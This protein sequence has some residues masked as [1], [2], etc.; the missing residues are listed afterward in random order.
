MNAGAKS[1]RDL[2]GVDTLLHSSEIKPLLERHSH[3]LV[4]YAIHQVLNKC[5]EQ[6]EA[7]L[8][9]PVMNHIACLVKKE[10][11]TIAQPGLK[12]V[13]NATGVIIHTNLGRA[14]V[15]PEILEE[16][17]S[18]LGG[19]S[20]LEFDLNTGKRGSRYSHLTPLLRYLTGA[21]D[22][23]VVN[24]NAAAVMLILH[25]MAFRKEVIISRS[26]LIEIGGS[27]RMPE[28][29]KASGCKMVEVGTTNKTRIDDYAKA[30]SPKTALLFKAH[31]SNYV[32][33][34]FTQQCTL[35]ELVSLGK[36]TGI[37][38]VYDMGSGLLRRTG[39]GFLNNEPD[40]AQ[41]LASGIDLVTFSGD[42]LLGGPQAGIIAGKKP[43]IER[44]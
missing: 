21:E 37:P 42:K 30:I 36:S 5:R 32:I 29:M 18:L 31:W 24:N 34:G 7:G 13:I 43:L 8:P 44:L 28:I 14:P 40:V 33:R 39:I 4:V 1:F 16:A 11:E 3:E 6:I 12:R 9:S 19:Y 41:T 22:I 25:N 35:E 23:L 26:E 38:V 15:A 20:N 27:F 17:H 10:I 2:P